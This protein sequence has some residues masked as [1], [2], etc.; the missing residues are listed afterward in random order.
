MPTYFKQLENAIKTMHY[1]H[2]T[3][4]GQTFGKRTIRLYG[5]QLTVIIIGA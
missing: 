2:G 1:R 5:R 4:T 3:V